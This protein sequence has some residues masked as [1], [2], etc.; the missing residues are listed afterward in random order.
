[1]AG[2]GFDGVWKEYDSDSVAVKDLTI[3]VE[4]GEFVVLVG[5]SGCG[6][7]TSLRMLAGLEEITEGT[8]EID[9]VVVNNLPPKARG[10]GMVFQSY[11]LYPH[12]S[13][14]KNLSFGL[15]M[16][17]G[18]GRLGKSEVDQRVSEAAELLGLSEYLDRLPK[19]LSGGQRQ[20]VALG[21]ALVRRPSVLLMDEPL[22]NLD[23][24]LRN[25]MRIEL[26]RLHEELGTTTIYVTHDQVEAMTLADRLVIMNEGRA[27][28]F[29]TPL[30]AYH[31]PSNTFVASF[32]GTP[33]MNLVEG[34]ASN[35]V[36]TYAGPSGEKD[37]LTRDLPQRY[38]TYEG[39][40]TLGFRP[41]NTG[42]KI[43]E[44][45]GKFTIAGFES[46]GSET[47]VHLDHGNLRI[48][49]VWHRPGPEANHQ[50]TNR[51]TPVKVVVEDQDIRL[52]D[53]TGAAVES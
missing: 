7:T 47:V 14:E 36:F 17:K 3:Q 4:S 2:V 49:A 43:G 18:E 12:M 32:L 6:K 33:P 19:N 53:D 52:F 15:R 1:M 27:Q 29:S 30:E 10:I 22:S 48:S 39:R 50:I 41:E 23:A 21:R 11:A 34:T 24:K 9:G 28:Q 46:L 8:I 38:S 31:N 20:R 45:G 25:Q 13:V 5:P 16:Q 26:R 35:G 37:S 44:E 42:L 51:S 40:C